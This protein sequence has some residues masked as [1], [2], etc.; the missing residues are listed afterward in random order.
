MQI[1]TVTGLLVTYKET[2]ALGLTYSYEETG[3]TFDIDFA[4][5]GEAYVSPDLDI[6]GIYRSTLL[7][8]LDYLN[9]SQ[10]ELVGDSYNLETAR[11]GI[12]ATLSRYD[13]ELITATEG[14]VPSSQPKQLLST[15][16]TCQIRLVMP[17]LSVKRRVRGNLD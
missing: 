12:T 5:A 16:V 13:I 9:V 11:C 14:D 10:N 3:D 2:G 17:C 8:N 4:V 7:E 15:I 6:S 1:R